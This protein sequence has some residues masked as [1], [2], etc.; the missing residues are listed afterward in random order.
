MR[1]RRALVPVLGMLALVATACPEQPGGG[2]P[3]SSTTTSTT[4][5][6]LADNDGDGFNTGQDCN[7]NDPTINPGQAVDTVGDGVDSN[8]DGT[9]GIQTNTVFVATTGQDI[10]TCGEALTPCATINQGLTRASS[11]GRTQVQVAGGTYAK[12]TVVA[13]FEIGGHYNSATW[14]KAGGTT[15]LVTAAFDATVN[16]PVGILASGISTP[17]KV[18]DLT[19]SG[20]AAGPGQRRSA[21]GL[22]RQP[23]C[24]PV[25]RARDGRRE[26][27]P[28]AEIAAR[29]GVDREAPRQAPER[30]QQLDGFG[31]AHA[32]RAGAR[33]AGRQRGR[34]RVETQHAA[35]PGTGGRVDD[36]DVVVPAAGLAHVGELTRRLARQQ[37]GRVARQQAPRDL[38]ARPVVAARGVAHAEHQARARAHGSSAPSCSRRSFRKCVAHEMQGS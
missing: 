6:T 18:S 3:T 20:V 19:V 38:A 27:A 2:G 29:D 21:A 9:D 7:D 10:S 16:G 11:L 23:P 31:H 1:V 28:V 5:T 13:G 14:L 25:D 15:T 24:Q 35:G 30:A 12:F 36:D 8:C 37:P 22:S 17:T 4:T 32:V 33:R 34:G 26:A